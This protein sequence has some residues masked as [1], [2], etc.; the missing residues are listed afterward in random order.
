[1]HTLHLLPLLGAAFILLHVSE[2][3]VLRPLP[4]SPSTSRSPCS[5]CS[6]AAGTST[7]SK[8]SV[9][10]QDSQHQGKSQQPHANDKDDDAL[11]ADLEG[12][13][14]QWKHGPVHYVE[15]GAETAAAEAYPV[16]LLPGTMRSNGEIEEEG[17]AKKR[18]NIRNQEA[19][20]TA[21]PGQ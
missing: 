8:R 7:T 5:P 16:L 21:S 20:G 14:Y 9:A 6:R 3:F 17:K 12:K 18:V 11:L 15:A 13:F 2:A 1:M 10:Y 4:L 19:K